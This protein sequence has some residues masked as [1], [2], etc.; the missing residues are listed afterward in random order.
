MP[1]V[2]VACSAEDTEYVV[3]GDEQTADEQLSA[4][5]SQ[6]YLT[7]DCVESV[8]EE[9]ERLQEEQAAIEAAD[10]YDEDFLACYTYEA[11]DSEEAE[12]D[13]AESESE[14]ATCEDVVTSML[15]GFEYCT[16]LEEEN[17]YYECSGIEETVNAAVELCDASSSEVT[18][19]F[20]SLVNPTSDS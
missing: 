2:W 19:D 8:T 6:E 20:C 11:A 17:K 18:E 3:S 14:E 1:I 13:S 12:E 16:A 10:S 4:C 5:Q 15:S 7:A 9:E